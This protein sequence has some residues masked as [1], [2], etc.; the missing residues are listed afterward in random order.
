VR[1]FIGS[2]V[3]AALIPIAYATGH[4]VGSA[5][6]GAPSVPEAIEAAGLV[7]DGPPIEAW[8][9][10]VT[11]GPLKGASGDAV[12]A[13]TEEPPKPGKFVRQSC[14]I[15]YDV[16]PPLGKVVTNYCTFEDV[17]RAEVEEYAR[18]TQGSPGGP[19]A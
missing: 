15:R 10:V 11:A 9:Y 16:Q 7:A 6:D 5:G 1:S 19:G 13:L 14:E 12:I 2:L 18:L 8:F 4:V 17:T 3:V